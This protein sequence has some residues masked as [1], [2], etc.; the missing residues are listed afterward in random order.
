M[1]LS[2]T[3]KN[4]LPARHLVTSQGYQ[5]KNIHH[6]KANSARMSKV[7]SWSPVNRTPTA[8]S[9]I[10][11]KEGEFRRQHRRPCAQSVPVPAPGCSCKDRRRTT[12]R[13]GRDDV[14]GLSEYP[15]QEPMMFVDNRSP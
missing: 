7:P 6:W 10:H 3:S 2:D 4:P 13:C 8:T 15:T 12:V 5:S 1:V 9:L 11:L 14:H